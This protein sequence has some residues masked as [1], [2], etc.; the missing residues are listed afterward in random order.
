MS[1]CEET[2]AYQFSAHNQSNLAAFLSCSEYTST[3]IKVLIWQSCHE[4][5]GCFLVREYSFAQVEFTLLIQWQ[6]LKNFEAIP[7]IA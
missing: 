4:Q 3:V 7:F 1:P 2:E 5:C 6:K